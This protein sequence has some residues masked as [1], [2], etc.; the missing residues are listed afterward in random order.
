MNTKPETSLLMLNR[1]LKALMATISGY[2]LVRLNMDILA[3]DKKL[4]FD[5]WLAWLA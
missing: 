2:A 4:N 5:K 3:P 1:G